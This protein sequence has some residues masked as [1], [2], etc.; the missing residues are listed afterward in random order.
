MILQLD[1]GKESSDRTTGGGQVSKY[2]LCEL[3]RSCRLSVHRCKCCFLYFGA[4][5]HVARSIILLRCQ[6][7]EI[8]SFGPLLFSCNLFRTLTPTSEREREIPE[9]Q[10]RWIVCFQIN[11]RVGFAAFRF[12][13][14]DVA[15]IVASQGQVASGVHRE[16]MWMP[17]IWETQSTSRAIGPFNQA[18]TPGGPARISMTHIGGIIS[19]Q[20][21]GKTKE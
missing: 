13:G 16:P 18:T 2:S 17:Q 3:S 9:H 12:D 20:Q 5:V 11:M 21:S 14:A 6:P 15:G 10:P 4:A 8:A 19:T 1:R 7:R